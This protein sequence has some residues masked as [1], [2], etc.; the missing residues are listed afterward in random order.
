M[1]K[2]IFDL[3][4]NGFSRSAGNLYTGDLKDACYDLTVLEA[5]ILFFGSL[6]RENTCQVAALWFSW[7]RSLAIRCG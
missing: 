2:A 3:Q 7:F 1:R 4:R 6:G 5:L